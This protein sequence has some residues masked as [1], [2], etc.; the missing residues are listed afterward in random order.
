MTV[1][2]LRQLAAQ[3]IQF[4][5]IGKGLG[6]AVLEQV[7][8]EKPD[9]VELVQR[10]A[11][12]IRF[13]QVFYPFPRALGGE[14][15]KAD[16]LVDERAHHAV[17]IRGILVLVCGGIDVLGP[18]FLPV[19]LPE[20]GIPDRLADRLRGH[21]ARP[22]RP[23]Q[24]VLAFKNDVRRL[25]HVCQKREILFQAGNEER[26][27]EFFGRRDVKEELPLPLLLHDLH[28]GSVFSL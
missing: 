28:D 17:F 7:F 13:I 1:A 21:V 11:L 25:H 4:A 15:E 10:R 6:I 16:G 20:G 9:E 22:L 5:V 14:V 24:L 2:Q 3:L 18:H 8:I 23:D 19:F 27:I 26:G 12:K